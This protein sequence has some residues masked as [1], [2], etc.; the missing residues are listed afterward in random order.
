MEVRI[1]DIN[2]DE[3][4]MKMKKIIMILLRFNQDVNLGLLKV[5][6]SVVM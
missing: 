6:F 2:V 3:N 4:V 1:V 5:V